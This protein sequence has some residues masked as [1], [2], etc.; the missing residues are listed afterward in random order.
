MQWL[1]LLLWTGLHKTANKDELFSEHW[2]WRRPA[3]KV[4]FSS[5]NH[6]AIKAALHC[7][8]DAWCWADGVEDCEGRP[9]LKKI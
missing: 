8:D 5:D 9:V 4:F 2:I 7:Q 3:V 6:S 1:A